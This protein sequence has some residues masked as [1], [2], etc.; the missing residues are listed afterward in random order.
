MKAREIRP[1]L[2]RF[3]IE[4]LHQQRQLSADTV[5]AYRDTF[6]LWIRYLQTSKRRRRAPLLLQ[7]LS[8]EEALAFLNYLEQQRENG[9][10]TRNARLAALHCFVRYLDNW[11]GP[12]LPESTRRILAIPFKRCSKPL[13]G[14]LTRVEMEALLGATDSTWTGRRDRLLFLLLYNT[15]ARVSEIIRLQAKDVTTSRCQQVQLQG[16]GRKHRV[17]PLWAQTQR[18]LRSW[19]SENQLGPD[20]ILL[21]N[22]FGQALSRSGVTWQLQKAVERAAKTLPSLTKRSISPHVL[23]HSTAMHLLQSGVALEVIALWLGHES[24][25]TTHHYIEADLTMKQ[26]V[27]RQTNPPSPKRTKR[28]S[29]RPDDDLL[30][31]LEGL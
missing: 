19:L 4:Y 31:F 5:R 6:R 17:L 2:Q 15:G 8:A 9:A 13:V 18:A 7:D 29:W 24:P 3:F 27:L 26:Q 30:R 20:D 12:E 22:R 25:E 23:R 10:R 16:K 21:P 14:F 28:K 11:L 1:V